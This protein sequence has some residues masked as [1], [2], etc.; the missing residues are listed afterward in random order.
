MARR[1]LQNIALG[2]LAAAPDPARALELSRRQYRAADNLTD[3]LAALIPI[4][5]LAVDMRSDEIPEMSDFFQRGTRFPLLRDRWFSLQAAADRPDT[6]A[7]V[8]RLTQHA[9][10]TRTNPNRVRA[11]LGTFALANPAAFHRADGSGYRLLGEEIAALDRLNAQVAARLAGPLSR[12]A[13]YAEP[14]RE[15]MR[16]ELTKLNA[17]PGLSRDLGEIVGKSLADT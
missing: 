14:F 13:R 8:R 5:E 2:Y 11:L 3:R 10:F 17:I 16:A 9:D 1:R 4:L 7:Q 6:T 15:M 12:W